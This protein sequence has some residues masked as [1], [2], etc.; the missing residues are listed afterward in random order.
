MT[1]HCKDSNIIRTSVY[2]YIS[3]TM[4]G[5]REGRGV[6]MRHKENT[7][8]IVF[9]HARG[10]KRWQTPQCVAFSGLQT[11]RQKQRWRQIQR[12]RE[13]N[14]HAFQ[15]WQSEY[16]KN[17]TSRHDQFKDKFEYNYKYKDTSISSKA[18][19]PWRP[20]IELLVMVLTVASAVD[21]IVEQCFSR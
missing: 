14:A 20:P 8:L 17:A 9:R 11:L 2:L 7:L 10:L 21:E 19:N 13:I 15:R 1:L 3:K 4:S 6:R 5:C 12:Q 18:G 16:P